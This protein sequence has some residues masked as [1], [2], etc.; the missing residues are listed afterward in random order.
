MAAMLGIDSV[1]RNGH[2]YFRGLSMFPHEAQCKTVDLH[3]DLY[4]LH[5]D[6]FATLSINDGHLH[7]DSVNRAP[8]GTAIDSDAELGAQTFNP[9]S[10]T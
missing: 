10:E 9:V 5:S 4:H 2:H 1:E 8:F 6:G 7:L 3:P